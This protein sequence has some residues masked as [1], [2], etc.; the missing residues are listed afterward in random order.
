MRIEA[1]ECS[2]LVEEKLNVKHGLSLR[3][4]R[5]LFLNRPRIRF[6]EQGHQEGEDVYAAFGQT[7]GGRYLS[8]FFIYKPA[9]KMAWVL[10]AR[11]MSPRE[12]KSYGRK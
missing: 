10:S 9:I 4:V 6:A 1:V 8:V 11:D 5:Q 12:R 7:F 3:E 2:E